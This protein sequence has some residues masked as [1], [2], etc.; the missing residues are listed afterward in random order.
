MTI[1]RE[2]APVWAFRIWLTDISALE[3][4]YAF[5]IRLYTSFLTLN[6]MTI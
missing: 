2:V 3:H 5:K 1:L 4:A 6:K